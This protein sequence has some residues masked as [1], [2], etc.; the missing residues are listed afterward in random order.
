M[1][2]PGDAASRNLLATHLTLAEETRMR[3]WEKNCRILAGF[4][5]RDFFIGKLT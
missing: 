2:N 3:N 5:Q 1:A 4:A